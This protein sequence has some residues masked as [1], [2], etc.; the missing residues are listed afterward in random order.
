MLLPI[1]SWMPTAKLL[2]QGADN[3]IKI[4]ACLIILTLGTSNEALRGP[5]H[6]PIKS[7]VDEA[8][9]RCSTVET[10][11]VLANTPTTVSMKQGRDLDLHQ[12]MARPKLI[13]IVAATSANL[14]SRLLRDRT[15]PALGWIA[16]LPFS[17]C[18]RLAPQG[19]QKA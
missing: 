3:M 1:V 6:I 5:K 18:I 9:L 14:C 4:I 11:F 17:Y 7:I 19:S 13:A 15:A 16:S 2:S 12:A 8:L 10:C